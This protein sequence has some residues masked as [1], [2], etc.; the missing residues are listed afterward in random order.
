M[1]LKSAYFQSWKGGP[2][3]L[4]WG[5]ANGMRQLQ[6]WLRSIGGSERL[7]LE[8]SC[9]AIDGNDI[10]AEVVPLEKDAGMRFGSACLTWYVQPALA[11]DFVEMLDGLASGASG[12]QYLDARGNKV[13]VE[14]S[15]GEYP[16]TL[17]PD[18]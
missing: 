11:G 15:V 17:H 13:A 5:D 9:T 1:T 10:T 8:A 3:V 12:H 6:D 2:T 4:F 18:R 16:E 7:A 14:I